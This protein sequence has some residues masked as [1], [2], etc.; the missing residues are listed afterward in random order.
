MQRPL[1]PDSEAIR[2]TLKVLGIGNHHVTELRILEARDHVNNQYHSTYG[3]YFDDPEALIKAALTIKR[4]L[5][6]Y[7]MLNPC[8]PD[9]L[10][11]ICNRLVRL[12]KGESTQDSEILRRL[13]L[14][15]DVDPIRISRI[16]STDEEHR[17][18]LDRARVIANFLGSRG[19]P[20][21]IFGNSGN[22]GHLL[23]SIDL[24]IDDCGLV[25]KCLK[26]LDKR[27][28]DDRV[29]VDTSVSNPARIWKLYGTP[30]C[31]GDS[32]P[33]RP[34]RMANLLEIPNGF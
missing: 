19:W 2:K 8:H 15:I 31:K 7:I 30:A 34:H 21:P 32:T 26:F 18:A 25:Q 12:G 17:L 10:S 13:W 23:Y 29:K 24:P 27:F 14:P 11:R 33:I 9:V 3:G 28:S 4:A 5:G 1:R 22:G 6:W 16:S 20:D